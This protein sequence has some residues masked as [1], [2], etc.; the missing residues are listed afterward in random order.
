MKLFFNPAS[1]FVRK[2]RMVAEERGIADQIELVKVTITPVSP[3]DSVSSSNPIG[4]I[5]SLQLDD[6]MSLFDS[7]VICDYLDSVGSADSLILS[8]KSRWSDMRLQAIADAMCDAGILIRYEGFVRPEEYRWD[9]W[10]NNQWLKIVRSIDALEADADNLSQDVT[11]GNI[12]LSCA[13]AYLDFRYDDR[14]WRSGRDKLSIWFK[15]FSDR[16]S[17][18][19]TAP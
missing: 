16:D 4:K 1:P 2:V 14:S 13:L 12:A 11:V 8:G 19:N 17:F 6:G 15:T 10:S 18:R 5:P 3:D 9:E 7:R